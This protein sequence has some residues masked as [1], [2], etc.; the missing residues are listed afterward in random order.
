MRYTV[1]RN[2]FT[3][4]LNSNLAKTI[5]NILHSSNRAAIKHAGCR[6]GQSRRENSLF[7]L[8]K[9]RGGGRDK[10]SRLHFY[11]CRKNTPL[12][13]SASHLQNNIKRIH[14][15]QGSWSSLVAGG[16]HD[17]RYHYQL[18]PKWDSSRIISSKVINKC[19]IY[20]CGMDQWLI[21]IEI[22]GKNKKIGLFFIQLKFIL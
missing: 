4:P 12:R 14:R 17:Y 8:R 19:A 2:V 21:K 9:T 3:C 5:L 20:R 1:T 6:R 11:N 16:S 18:R 15:D 13:S 7:F 10:N 22:K